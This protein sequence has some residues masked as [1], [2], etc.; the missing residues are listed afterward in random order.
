M[1]INWLVEVSSWHK[2]LTSCFDVSSKSVKISTC[3][4]AVKWD[5]SI[6]NKMCWCW[7]K[8]QP[9]GFLQHHLLYIPSEFPANHRNI[10]KFHSFQKAIELIHFPRPIHS[11]ASHPSPFSSMLL[12]ELKSPVMHHRC[13]HRYFVHSLNSP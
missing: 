9:T 2:M 1:Y 3:E 4:M 10:N 12:M 8:V 6:K 11:N 7:P 5:I 13:L